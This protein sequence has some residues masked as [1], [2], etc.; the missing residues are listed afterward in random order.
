MA[1]TPKRTS[2]FVS[3]EPDKLEGFIR[4]VDEDL[5]KLFLYLDRFP[6]QISAD[7]EPT[8]SADE[9]V[10]WHDSGDDKMYLVWKKNGNQKKIELI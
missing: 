3:M 6:R 4:G 9:W 10:L 2:N 7:T 8:L 5:R 1:Q